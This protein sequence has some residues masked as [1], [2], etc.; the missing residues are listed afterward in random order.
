M[1]VMFFHAG[2]GFSGGYVGV[3]VFFV[4]S[5]YLITSVIVVD[6]ESTAFNF[7]SFWERR[8]RRIIPALA[9]LVL[10]T[11]LI[12]WFILLPKDY[13]ELGRATAYQSIFAANLFFWRA[14][15]YGYFAGASDEIP[16]LHTWSL[17]VEEQFYLIVPLVL[18]ALFRIHRPQNRSTILYIIGIGILTSLS[19]SAYG[20]A[21]TH[22]I[23]AFYL[24]PA[25]AWELLIGSALS[26]LRSDCP[27]KHRFTREMGSYIGLGG[28]L[29]PCFLYSNST[30]FPGLAALPPCLGAG[31]ILWSNC[32][33]PDK[34]I[35]TSLGRFLATR[36]MVFIG[37]ISYS[38]Y[39]WH[40][41]IF[42]FSRY[43]Y[44]GTGSLPLWYRFV[45]FVL[46]FVLATLSWRFI[47]TPFRKKTVFARNVSLY[48]FG[49]GTL[50]LSLVLGMAISMLNGLPERLPESL[51][52]ALAG[53][54]DLPFANELNA[55]DLA[56]DKLVPF[57]V[58]DLSLPVDLVVWGDSH[59]MAALPAFDA[60]LK[61]KRLSGRAA[62]H[63]S[64]APVLGYFSV[65]PYGLGDQAPSFNEAVISYVAKKHVPNVVMIARWTGYDRS[66]ALRLAL[67]STVKKLVSAGAQP[68]IFVEVPNH[69]FDVGRLLRRR[70]LPSS[71]NQNRYCGRPGNWNCAVITDPTF[72][73]QLSN[74][75]AK[76]IDPRPAFLNS[77]HDA[78]LISLDGIM[79]YRDQHHLTKS[80]AERILIPVLERILSPSLQKPV[81][82]AA[83]K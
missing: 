8:V 56:A 48:K 16:L 28:I 76:I 45:I 54:N 70:L 15:M 26:L 59:A 55:N 34:A 4:I 38:L 68:W 49:I 50:T 13:A 24:L 7:L 33:S 53:Q 52:T 74:A 6:L 58:R 40:W 11:L 83:G 19:V 18:W 25:R 2:F 72:L 42:A 43:Y 71:L 62:T 65:A 75:G 44:L 69:P 27:I 30:P 36:P 1:A 22:R 57:G 51:R 73:D 32:R 63:S 79:L 17:A 37:L 3:D 47:E 78:Y 77:N 41:P 9:A 39:L 20:L 10:A 46:G 14:R 21:T 66:D 29:A 31:L 80:G 61:Q 67:L 81:A 82:S 23:A 35:P 60:L 5:G 64:T 12:G